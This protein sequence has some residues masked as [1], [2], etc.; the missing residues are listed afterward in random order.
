MARINKIDL[1]E[2]V[3]DWVCTCGEENKF[4]SIIGTDDYLECLE[5]GRRFQ[6]RVKVIIED[7]S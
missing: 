3:V 2:L 4:T 6:V 5:C 1:L 7:A